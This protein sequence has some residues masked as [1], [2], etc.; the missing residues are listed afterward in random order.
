VR[1]KW[2]ALLAGTAICLAAGTAAAAAPA[3]HASITAAT[4]ENIITSLYTSPGDDTTQWGDVIADA[5]GNGG[6]VG[7]VIVDSCGND[8][9][10]PGCNNEPAD[11]ADTNWVGNGG[12]QPVNYLSELQGDGV[13]PLFYVPTGY[14]NENGDDTSTVGTEAYI[15]SMMSAWVTEYEPYFSSGGKFGFMLDTVTVGGSYADAADTLS[16]YSELYTYAVDLG[17]SVV[18]YNPG[19]PEDES[20]W[21][22]GPDEILQQFEGSESGFQSQTWPSWMSGTSAS[23]FSATVTD[24]SGESDSSLVLDTQDAGNAGIGNIYIENEGEPNPNYQTLPSWWSAENTEE[25]DPGTWTETA[26]NPGTDGTPDSYDLGGWCIQEDGTANLDDME[27][28]KCSVN[29]NSPNQTITLVSDGT[30]TNPSNLFYNYAQYELKFG[31]SG[32]CITLN[33]LQGAPNG[34]LPVLGTCADANDQLF[35]RLDNT[36]G[37]KTFTSPYILNHGGAY[38]A[39][40]DQSGTVAAGNPIDTSGVSLSGGEDTYASQNFDMACGPTAC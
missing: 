26:L 36:H 21:I 12:S 6:A 39:I 9:N 35:V 11:T 1:R 3:A 7:D 23:R 30:V 15:E 31:N 4:P 28:E 10:G 33:G 20:N 24:P 16:F 38:L 34:G 5:A 17:A 8:G 13:T 14:Y 29:V 32:K 25:A 22:F 27:L 2:Q 37:N 19:A 18:M 40:D